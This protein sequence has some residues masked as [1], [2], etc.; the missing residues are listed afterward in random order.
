M[1]LITGGTG[2]SSFNF[3]CPAG[4]FL[5]GFHARTGA[6]FDAIGIVCTSY[7]ASTKTFAGINR[8]PRMAG[9]SGGGEQEKYCPAGVPI[10][11]IG[12]YPNGEGQHVDALAITC[13]TTSGTS[14]YDCISSGET[15][16]P[17]PLTQHVMA[18]HSCPDG[19]RAT[20]IHGRADD[21]VNAL[22][23]NCDP[24]PAAEPPLSA[25]SGPGGPIR[26]MGTDTLPPSAPPISAPPPADN[27]LTGIDLPGK[28][29]QSVVLNRNL[30]M[31]NNPGDT[32]TACRNICAIEERCKAWT[33]VKPGIQ[34][35]NAMCWLKNEIPPRVANPNTASGIKVSRGPVR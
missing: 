33:Y 18:R 1:T 12:V 10:S 34:G 31:P 29:Y 19:E 7:N 28:D 32:P 14:H 11:G 5:I 13:L 15:C 6:W 26:R 23:L 8:D 22:G 25:Q 20:G 27:I 17:D 24:L 21:A 16:Y 9:G 2:G 35:K 3:T 4:Q 30:A